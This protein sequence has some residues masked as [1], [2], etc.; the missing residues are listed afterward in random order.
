MVINWKLRPFWMPPWMPPWMPSWMP[1][2]MPLLQM[3]IMLIHVD[4][5]LNCNGH[6]DPQNLGTDIKITILV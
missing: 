5:L 4:I 2:W 1:S 6:I 3:V